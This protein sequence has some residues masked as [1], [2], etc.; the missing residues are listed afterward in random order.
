MPDDADD[1]VPEGYEVVAVAT[2][3]AEVEVLDSSRRLKKATA[4]KKLN[5]SKK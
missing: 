2:P 4:A 1:T 3:V 5:S